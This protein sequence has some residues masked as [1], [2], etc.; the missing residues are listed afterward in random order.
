MATLL[1]TTRKKSQHIDH[2]PFVI[3]AT[4]LDE[5]Q[6]KPILKEVRK[7]WFEGQPISR[8][9]LRKF[10]DL[11][12]KDEQTKLPYITSI[13]SRPVSWFLGNPV[14]TGEYVAVTTIP[15]NGEHLAAKPGSDRPQP[16]GLCN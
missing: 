1:N 8:D 11:V 15:G 6:S 9:T 5:M 16:S 13:G 3:R 7:A 14:Q 10:Y 12:L 4:F 2:E